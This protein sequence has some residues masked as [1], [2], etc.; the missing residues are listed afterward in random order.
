M[1]ER[2]GKIRSPSFFEL[3]RSFPISTERLA[4]IE[5]PLSADGVRRLLRRMGSDSAGFS[6]FML[7]IQC[8]ELANARSPPVFELYSSEKFRL[9]P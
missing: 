1:F 5:V 7:L 9:V 6:F 2:L 3:Q 8:R 4:P